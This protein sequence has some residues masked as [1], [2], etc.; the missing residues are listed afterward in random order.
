MVYNHFKLQYNMEWRGTRIENTHL[1]VCPQC[2]D[3]P[4]RQ[5]GVNITGIDPMSILNARPEPY[6]MDEGPGTHRITQNGRLRVV[7]GGY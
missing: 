7:Q 3:V 4:Q 2:L 6:N 5:L 1:L